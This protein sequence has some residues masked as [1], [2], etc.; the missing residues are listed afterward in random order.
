MR[1]QFHECFTGATDKY[2][3][4]SPDTEYD[5]RAKN[6][7]RYSILETEQ[8]ENIDLSLQRM[9]WAAVLS[10]N[11]SLYNK[12]KKKW[13]QDM[14]DIFTQIQISFRS[15]CSWICPREHHFVKQRTK[16]RKKR[17]EKIRSILILN[18]MFYLEAMRSLLQSALP[19][20]T[21]LDEWVIFIH[22]R[23]AVIK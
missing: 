6:M 19:S 1:N 23:Y 16:K 13:N 7:S 12:L 11:W 15:G 5:C 20:I 22:G 18:C 9:N 4:L 17:E 10:T 3:N 14:Y 21:E 8:K 2:E